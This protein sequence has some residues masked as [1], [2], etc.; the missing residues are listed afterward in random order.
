MSGVHFVN[1]LGWLEYF[2]DGPNAGRVAELF[3]DPV[4]WWSLP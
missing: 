3:S 1:S 2:A 4:G